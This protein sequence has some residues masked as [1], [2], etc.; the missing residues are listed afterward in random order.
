MGRK[1]CYHVFAAF[2]FCRERG[3]IV[4]SNYPAYSV[5]MT[6]YHLVPPKYF[7]RALGSMTNQTLPPDQITIVCDGPLTAELDAVIAKYENEHPQ[8][9]TVLRYPDHQGIGICNN[10][11]LEACRNDIVVRM[12]SDDISEPDRCMME[13]AEFASA[14]TLDIVSGYIL[15]FEEDENV[16][17]LRTV[18]TER[19]EVLRYARRRMPFSNVT[20]A[21]RKSLV[22]Q[23]GGYRD[24][25]RAEDYDMVARML[26]AGANFKVLPELMV[27]V[28]VDDGAFGRRKSWKHISSLIGV[29]WGLYRMGFT[30]LW[31]FIVMAGSHLVSLLMPERLIRWLYEKKLR[32]PYKPEKKDV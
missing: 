2:Y 6:V 24:L 9:L 15:E 28:R 30:S 11:G 10:L 1:S 20:I 19:E 27:R 25:S 4:N 22:Q 16:G 18:P 8:L 7:D 21:Y 31:D 5:L 14:P 12:D 17:Y 32:T 29:R 13:L 23:C 3:I 26:M